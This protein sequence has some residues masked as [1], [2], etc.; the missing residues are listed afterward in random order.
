M[1]SNLLQF[2]VSQNGWFIREH[3]IK[4]DDLGAPPF[5]EKPSIRIKLRTNGPTSLPQQTSP[6]CFATHFFMVNP[7][8]ST[9]KFR[10]TSLISWW[11]LEEN[12][13]KSN[14]QHPSPFIS[15]FLRSRPFCWAKKTALCVLNSN[16]TFFLHGQPGLSHSNTKFF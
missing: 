13:S 2:L 4:M 6:S 14:I 16:S 12:S 8:I 5:I 11:D 9:G 1:T 3:P 15:C 7:K 10:K